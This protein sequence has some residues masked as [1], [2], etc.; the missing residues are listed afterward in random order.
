MPFDNCAA[1]LAMRLSTSYIY[2]RD[3]T[4]QALIY[5]FRLF[6][7]NSAS[8]ALYFAVREARSLSLR[9]APRSSKVFKISLVP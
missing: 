8:L 1:P 7:A 9:I 5:I 3:L 4:K 2:F 6:S